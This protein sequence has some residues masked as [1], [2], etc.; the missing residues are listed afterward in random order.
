MTRKIREHRAGVTVALAVTAAIVILL[1]GGALQPADRSQAALR[2]LRPTGEA[3]LVSI[4]P[5]P[6]ME[7]ESCQWQPASSQQRL[8]AAV[9]EERA[10]ARST[11]ADIKGSTS[12]DRPPVRMIR[13]PYPTYSAVV[14]DS[15]HNEIILQDENLFQIMTYDRLAN[16]PPTATMTEPKRVIGGPATH[17]EFNCGLYVDPKNGDIYSVNNDTIDTM[18]V[19]SREAKG[20][21]P[22]TRALHT[23]HRTFGIAVNE[24]AQEL[25]LTVEH[26]PAIVVYHKMAKGDDAP[27]RIIEGNRTLLADP[28]GIALDTKNKVMYVT[29]HGSVAS[30]KDGKNFTRRPSVSGGWQIP[31]ERERREVMVP[32]SGAYHPPTI[33]VYPMNGVGDVAP[34]RVIEGPETQLNWPAQIYFD[35]EHSDLYVANDTG[36]SILVFKGGDKGNVAPTRVIKGSKT[37]IKNPTG[38]FLDKKNNELVVANMGNH[39]ATVYP[40]TANGDVAPL[41]TIR[42]APAGKVALDIGN[43]GAV[44]YDTKRDQILVPN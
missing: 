5:L 15:V 34:L 7:G 41:R 20:N 24:E 3:Q 1:S 14:V 22:P 17:V 25:F 42:A 29:N 37:G 19:F 16:T 30:S 23:P 26:P 21:V 43:P 36:D 35:E 6:E 40:R 10:A 44:G 2:S 8:I 28:H 4:E 31:D 11:A 39:S 32:G 27:I 33:T 13:D 12:I 9:Q 18:T 38:V